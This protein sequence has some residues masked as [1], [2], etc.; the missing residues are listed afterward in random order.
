MVAF[1]V[2]AAAAA[3]RGL[4][5]QRTHAAAPVT[6]LTGTR[7]ALAG[8]PLHVWQGVGPAVPSCLLRRRTDVAASEARGAGKG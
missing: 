5:I 7:V 8:T 6:T 2:A 3:A 4:Y 1:F